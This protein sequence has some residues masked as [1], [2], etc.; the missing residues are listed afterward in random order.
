[1]DCRF[2]PE[3]GALELHHPGGSWIA[4]DARAAIAAEDATDAETVRA[5]LAAAAGRLP[6]R[7]P[8]FIFL[9]F[10]V[11]W[12]T[13]R[14]ALLD[15]GAA[16][17]LA[18]ADERVASIKAYATVRAGANGNLTFAIKEYDHAASAFARPAGW[19]VFAQPRAVRWRYLRDI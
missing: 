2:G 1:M 17:F 6:E 12:S 7:R 16:L 3:P 13:D 5:L 19:T 8:G 10:P 18:A 15:E 14:L 9:Q 4:A 11:T